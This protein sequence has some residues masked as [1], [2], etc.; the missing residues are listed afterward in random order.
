MSMIKDVIMLRDWISEEEAD[1]LIYEAAY[2][3]KCSL[4]TGQSILHICQDYF[5][6]DNSYL[7]ELIDYADYFVD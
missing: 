4:L 1:I 5:D 2:E 6:L 7:Q 3:L